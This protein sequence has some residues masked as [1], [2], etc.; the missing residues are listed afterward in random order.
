MGFWWNRSMG[1]TTSSWAWKFI[2]R[3]QRTP[4]NAKQ[5]LRVDQL[6]GK[7]LHNVL[8]VELVDLAALIVC[9]SI[10]CKCL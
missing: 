1:E 4:M 9:V 8:Q 7:E 6:P 5:M 2:L 10:W 3:F